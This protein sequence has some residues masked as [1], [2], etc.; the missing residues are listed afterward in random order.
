MSKSKHTKAPWISVGLTVE[1]PCDN[2]PDICIMIDE[3]RDMEEAC[4]NSQLIAAAPEMLR[5][6]R[7]ISKMSRGDAAMCAYI[8]QNAIRDI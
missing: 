2:T 4:A 5:A 6:L 3:G 8:A 7:T 1:H